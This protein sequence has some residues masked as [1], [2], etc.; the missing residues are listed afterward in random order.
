MFDYTLYFCM[1]KLTGIMLAIL[2]KIEN[3]RLY[4]K[5]KKN[6]SVRS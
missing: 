5:P 2:G 1:P 3:F 4:H 6:S